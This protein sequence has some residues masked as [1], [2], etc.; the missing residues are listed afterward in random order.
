MKS[1]I[2]I[3]LSLS[4]VEF[5]G[6]SNE[7]PKEAEN[8]DPKTLSTVDLTSTKIPDLS[9]D[10][11]VSVYE[12]QE[13]IKISQEDKALRKQYCDQSYLR[14][15]KLFI[16]MGI[17]KL[18]NPQTGETIPSSMAERAAIIDAKRWA[19]YGELWLTNDYETPFGKLSKNFQRTV[20]VI[21]K[22]VVGD[23]LFVFMA[24]S[25]P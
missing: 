10:Y 18:T 7:K 19:S 11:L 15:H 23:S 22:S 4:L 14:E 3:I 9:S 5:F 6:C 20:T 13:L 2:L 8:F 24:T 16:S 25:L 1:I 17:G 12:K 21:N